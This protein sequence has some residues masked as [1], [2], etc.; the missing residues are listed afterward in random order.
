MLKK[1][2]FSLV[3]VGF[4]GI[5]MAQAMWCR[6]HRQFHREPLHTAVRQD[7]ERMVAW[8]LSSRQNADDINIRDAEGSTPLHIAVQKGNLGMVKL[9]VEQGADVLARD[10]QGC[11]PACCT[12]CFEIHSYLAPYMAAQRSDIAS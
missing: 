1:S 8:L 6:C 2:I 11:V 5:S 12:P 3:I 4:F 10:A 7:D 9:L